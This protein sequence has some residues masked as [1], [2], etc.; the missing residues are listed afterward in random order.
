MLK[1]L[2][3]FTA[4]TNGL[5][6]IEFAFIAPVLVTLLLGSVE[7]GNALECRQKVTVLASSAADLVAQT[8]SVSTS[9]LTNIF[10]AVT[11]IVY[12]FPQGTTT[13][14]ISSIMS[15]GKGGGYVAWSKAQNGSALAT[16]STVTLPQPLM[17]TCTTSTSCTACAKSA[18]SVILAQVSYSYT[19]AIGKLFSKAVSMKDTFYAHPRKSTSVTCT[20]CT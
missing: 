19:S 2:R 4:A 1:L 7:I 11:A 5:A 8:S 3:R 18:C 14:V 13:I 15:D 9:D 16:N 6:A 10:S 20:D 12:P 17:S